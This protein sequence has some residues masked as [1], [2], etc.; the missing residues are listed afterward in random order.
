MNPGMFKS[1]TR[2]GRRERASEKENTR[3]L[4]MEFLEGCQCPPH[5]DRASSSS[6]NF[7]PAETICSL[8]KTPSIFHEIEI[9]SEFVHDCIILEDLQSL[10]E[11]IRESNFQSFPK[12]HRGRPRQHQENRKSNTLAEQARSPPSSRDLTHR[13]LEPHH[14]TKTT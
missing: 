12:T 9:K 14:A 2:E 7:D 6:T 11:F 1:L 5:G 4:C 3:S 13:H 10:G 8:S